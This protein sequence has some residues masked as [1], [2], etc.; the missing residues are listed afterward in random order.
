MKK[1][2]N[3]KYLIQGSL[4]ASVYIVLTFISFTFGLS[5]GMVQLRLSEALCILPVFFPSAIPGLFAGCFI[6]N[7]LTGSIF[8]DVLFGSLATL[9]GAIFTRKLRNYKL[10]PF[11]PPII[12]NAFIL[13]F[14]LKFAYSFEGSY[15][16]FFITIFIGEFLSCGVL[17]YIFKN[18]LL[19]YEKFF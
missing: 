19:K 8:P 11:A 17:G 3:L 7:I 14:V 5:G 2:F 13:P 4:I 6:S 12:S 16:L 10:L 9:I 1:I 18:L 15:F